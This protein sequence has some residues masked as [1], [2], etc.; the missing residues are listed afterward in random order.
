MYKIENFIDKNSPEPRGPFP[1]I[2]LDQFYRVMIED[3]GTQRQ[4][5]FEADYGIVLSLEEHVK[6][7]RPHI[8]GAGAECAVCLVGEVP[9]NPT[10]N[11]YHTGKSDAG[12][13][14]IRFD[15]GYDSGSCTRVKID[16]KDTDILISVG[17]E[18]PEYVIFG[19]API[20]FLRNLNKVKKFAPPPINVAKEHTKK[21]EFWVPRTMLMP[22]S[23]LNKELLKFKNSSDSENLLQVINKLTKP[24][25]KAS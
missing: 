18:F 5:N 21:I 17:G 1:K 23:M 24:Y 12:I 8:I 4:K 9:F 25:I 2:S 15:Y 3:L 6:E 16:D 22:F 11:E 14:E 20:S 13:C 7:R 19:F 10:I